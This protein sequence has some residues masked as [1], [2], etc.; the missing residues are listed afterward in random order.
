MVM[1]IGLH[2]VCDYYTLPSNY[3]KQLWYVLSYANELFRVGVPLFFMISGYLLLK[4]PIT[5]IKAF[6][7]RRF[8]KILVPFVFYDVFY[9]LF[10]CHI[11]GA[12]ASLS[13][14]FK[15]LI[16][17]G[18]AYHLWFI[19]SIL[20]MYLMLPFLKIIVDNCSPRM[21]MLAFVLIV[22]QSTIK[23]FF[24]EF[25][26]TDTLGN[27]FL[28]LTEDGIIGYLGY[29]LLGY[30]LGTYSLGKKTLTMLYAAAVAFFVLTPVISTHRVIS[31]DT[32]LMHSGYALNHYIEA[33]ALFLLFKAL[34]KAPC[35]AVTKLSG[36]SFG[37]Y[38]I[39]VFILELLKLHVHGVTPSVKM[40]ISFV[41][42]VLAS[43]LWGFAEK[44]I[45]KLF[46]KIS[47][48]G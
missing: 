38:F 41:V 42:A 10:F 46:K 9:Y 35:K 31:G 1:V 11:Y 43:F 37:A 13:G 23:P 19:Y 12:E 39:H 5:D 26:Q 30:I 2:C 29:I 7:K 16:G 25:L 18:S 45:A 40:V 48:A 47:H 32:F 24:N 17:I 6:Y 22:F 36:V 3:G 4:N 34:A 21:V 33:A 28:H 14:F 8:T 20:F 44:E 27:S 15:E